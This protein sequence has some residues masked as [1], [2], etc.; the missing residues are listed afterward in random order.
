[1]FALLFRVETIHAKADD[2]FKNYDWL[3]GNHSD[4]LT[5]WIPIMAHLSN[6]HYFVL[7]CCPFDLFGKYQ[8]SCQKKSQYRDYLDRI[9]EIGRKCGYKVE[10][11]KLRIPSTKRICFVGMKKSEPIDS[12][13]L[14]ALQNQEFKA[15]PSEEIV[16]NCTKVPKTVT[17][18]IIDLIVKSLLNE[19]NY[20]IQE[21]LRWNAGKSLALSEI[22]SQVLNPQLL[23]ELKNECGGLQTL[24]RNHNHIFIVMDKGFVRL[25]NPAQDDHSLGK[26]RPNAQAV[27]KWKKTK[28][29]WFDQNHPQGCPSNDCFWIH[30]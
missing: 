18:E 29:C 28:P 7:P 26:K 17:T 2:Y 16:K 27:N 13:L 10:E 1:M 3:I 24:L 12:D 22:S 5:P 30:S 21:N 8:R 15:R 25:R 9:D 11:D 14:Q 20:Y 23:K 6:A 4:E 19:E